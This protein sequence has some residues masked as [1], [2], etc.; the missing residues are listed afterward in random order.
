VLGI[1]VGLPRWKSLRQ[2]SYR[3]WVQ[4]PDKTKLIECVVCELSAGGG[5]LTPSQPID[6]PE[7]FT[8]SLTKDG[9]AHRQCRVLWKSKKAIGVRFL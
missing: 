2:K 7:E 4:S 1:R 8:V 6:I 5:C 9:T 3:A